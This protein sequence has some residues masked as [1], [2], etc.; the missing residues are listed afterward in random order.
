LTL[1]YRIVEQHQGRLTY[2]AVSGGGSQ[3]TIAIPIGQGASKMLA[4]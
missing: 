4:Q 2:Q 3:F 1:S